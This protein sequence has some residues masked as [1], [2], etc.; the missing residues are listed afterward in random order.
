MAN[1]SLRAKAEKAVERATRLA[2]A[3]PKVGPDQ[4]VKAS[5]VRNALE[6]LR[7]IAEDVARRSL[8]SSKGTIAGSGWPVDL[9]RILSPMYNIAEDIAGKPDPATGY[10]SGSATITEADNKTARFIL[11]A[12]D[13]LLPAY[14]KDNPLERDKYDLIKRE[15]HR[16]LFIA[17]DLDID[18]TVFDKAVTFWKSVKEAVV[19][20]YKK[21]KDALKTGMSIATIALII[22]AA[23]GGVYVAKTLFG[24]RE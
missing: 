18:T 9:A 15:A 7:P 20:L 8:G 11:F 22:A 10:L 4:A 14:G 1:E 16:L 5:Y 13:D 6:F 3:W 2:N 24:G 21:G 12:L 19:D 17:T 23:A